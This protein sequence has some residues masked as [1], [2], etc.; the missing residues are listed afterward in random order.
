MTT[1]MH[2]LAAIVVVLLGMLLSKATIASCDSSQVMAEGGMGCKGDKPVLPPSCPPPPQC[3]AFFG[4]G[5]VGIGDIMKCGITGFAGGITPCV[6]GAIP[7]MKVSSD[8]HWCVAA[9]PDCEGNAYA[10]G[11]SSFDPHCRKW[12]IIPEFAVDPNDKVGTL[13]VGTADYIPAGVPISYGIHF[14]NLATATGPAAE[15]VITDQLDPSV[16]DL[17]TFAFGPM[18]FGVYTLSPE[19]QSQTFRGGIDLQPTQAV[20]VAVRADLDRATGLVTWRFSSID[21]ATAQATD[22]PSSGFLPPNTNPPDGEGAV[23]FTVMPKAGLATG[24]A[25]SNR[26]SVV[27]DA[28][29]PIATP[30]W[31]NTID[32][33][34]PASHVL[35]LPASE[36]ATS[37]PVSWTGFDTGSGIATYTVSV[38]DNGGPFTIWQNATTATSGIYQGATG[39]RYDFYSIAVDLVGNR[40]ANKTTADA[41]TTVGAVAA[42][43]HNVTSSIAITRSGYSYNLATRRFA[44]TVTLRNATANAIAGPIA[45]ALDG[46]PAGVALFNPAGTTAC[47][48]PAGDPFATTTAGLPAGGTMTFSLQFDNPSRVGIGYVPRVLAGTPR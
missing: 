3:A 25:V 10:K 7:G 36:S 4:K 15:V 1:R 27:F 30:T 23:M 18:T 39:H 8:G 34:A 17:S 48:L 46:L 31:V 37:F 35:A 5:D 45:L 38:S 20:Q 29:A 33:T 9:K 47:A 22:D 43:A 26:A 14:E 19:A 28:N 44:Q 11:I 12:L 40:E 41:S 6:C 24:T 32:R 16:V 42:C 21:P 2:R 13:G